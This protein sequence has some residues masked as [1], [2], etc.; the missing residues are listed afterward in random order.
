MLYIPLTGLSAK[1]VNLFKRMAAF[2]NPEFYEKQGMR[3]STYNI[4]QV[5]SCSELYDEYIA[6]PRGCEDAIFNLLTQRGVQITI[7]DQ[8]NHGHSIDV[9][10]KGELLEEQQSAMEA[11]LR[12]NIGTL[13]TTTAFGKTVFAIAM[14]AKRRVNTLIL[15]HNKALLEQW[16]ERLGEFLEIRNVIEEPVGKR[17]RKRKDSVIGCLYSGRNTLHGIVD[18]ALIQS[19][20]N[21]GDAK[22]FVKDYGMVIVDECHHVSSVSFEQVLRQVKA[23]YIYGLTATP[24]RKD[25]HQPI[26]FMQCGQI[27]FTSSSKDQIAKQTFKRTLIPRFTTYCSIADR[28]TNYTQIT[29]SLSNDRARNEL[30]IEDIKTAIQHGRTPLVL[31]TRTA[32]V[33]V[34]TQMLLPFA[35]NIIQLIGADSTKEKRSALQKLQSVSQSET[36]IIVATGKYIGEGFDYPRLDTLFLT[37]PISWK[38]NIEQYSGRLHREYKGK[39][40]VQI[41][42][43]VDIRIPLCDSMYRKRLKGYMAAGYGKQDNYSMQEDASSN[44][45]YTRD[46]YERVFQKDLIAAKHSVVIAVPRIRYKYKPLI[47]EILSSLLR[48]GIEISVRFK[49]NGYNET[50]LANMGIDVVC[51]NEQTLLCAII[52]KSIVW[53]GN[54]NFLSFISETSNIMRIVD[55]NIANEMIG[56]LYPPTV[57]YGNP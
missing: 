32:H 15:V 12:Y 42:D 43:Y 44:L 23:T 10:F 5:I 21:A 35:D 27:R 39:N 40:E 18:I 52:D 49:E 38:G 37:M 6:L 31:T 24:I 25:G 13:S 48:K 54:I 45:I 33:K 55:H 30:I 4:P 3:L 1:C 22:V 19:C 16:K 7:S 9:L 34:L 8:T 51:N 14:I 46:N 28:T 20:L 17:G 11:M 26:I 57:R 47:I 2:R 36:L 29:E 53:Y 56:I 41:Y 50:D